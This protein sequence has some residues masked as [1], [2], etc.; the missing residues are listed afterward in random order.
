[1]E[2]WKVWVAFRKPKDILGNSKRLKGGSNDSFFLDVVEVDRNLMVGSH[3]VNFVKGVTA[4]KAVGVS[5]GCV[6]LGNGRG[7]CERSGLCNHHKASKHC[8]PW[9]Q[10]GERTTMGPR[11]V[12]LYRP[13]A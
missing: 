9:A 7:W 4:G 10:D 1:M 5:H 2:R 3:E 6:G 13:A 8:P 11:H 12:W